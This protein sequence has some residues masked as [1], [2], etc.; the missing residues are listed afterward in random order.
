MTRYRWI[1][2]RPILASGY[3]LNDSPLLCEIAARRGFITPESVEGFLSPDL[4]KL[5]D[6]Y[7]LP[8]MQLAVERITGA[9]DSEQLIGIFGDYDVDGITSTAVLKRAIDMLGGKALTYLPHRMRDGYGL[10]IAA[11]DRMV[12]DGVSLLVALDCG[13]SDTAEIAHAHAAGL[14]TVVVDHHHV[15]QSKLPN[16]AFVSA[17][18]ADSEFPFQQLA[19]VG[20]TYNLVRALLGEERASRLLPLVALGTVAD[21]VPLV[22]ENR[23]LVSHGLRRFAADAV[24]GLQRLA[25]HA[26]LDP[27]HISSY[28]CGYILGP[29]INAAGRMAEPDIALELLLTNDR[30]RADELA[31]KLGKLN[32]QR[33]Q[34]VRTML[35]EADEKVRQ[36]GDDLPFFVVGGAGW[37][38]GL[39]GLVAGR[40]TERYYRPSLALSVGDEVSRGSARSIE[41]FN[42]AEALHE[43]SNLLLEHGGHSQA[44]G[45]SLRTADVPALEARLIELAE[46]TFGDTVPVK[47]VT[48]DAELA[49]LE[50]NLATARLLTTL[51][52]FGSGNPAPRFMLRSVKV[53]S[54]R[55]TRD[56]KHVQFDLETAE[57]SVARA[58]FFDGAARLLDLHSRDPF[59]LLLE[60]KLD[61]WR[62]KA[63][64]KVEVLDFRPTEPLSV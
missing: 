42:I 60:L 25:Q 19:A 7:L 39:V 31:E 21:V 1:E 9:I 54:P 16:T 20:V 49:G 44:A 47:S 32:T 43:C 63:Q 5:S 4:M 56:G 23:T 45:L 46:A 61:N 48:I 8:D 64:L 36:R 11:I 3:A 10:N 15:G 13:T 22:G 38:V 41:G 27:T 62:G 52:P 14:R 18:R 12:A 6:P 57:G 51:E 50:V 58:I 33:Q 24:L 53:R 40:L 37:S 2:P 26:G 30:C 17:Q 34:S 35:E 28:H 59:D 29:R 55:R